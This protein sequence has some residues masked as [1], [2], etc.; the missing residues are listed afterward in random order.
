MRIDDDIEHEALAAHA[1]F[2][3]GPGTVEL[4]PLA[5]PP[6]DQD[7]DCKMFASGP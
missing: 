7:R 2:L 4:S 1:A 3:A 5:E 6:A